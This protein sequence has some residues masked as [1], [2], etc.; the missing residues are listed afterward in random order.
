M[1]RQNARGLTA[2]EMGVRL[3]DV[4]G[5]ELA[6]IIEWMIIRL[7]FTPAQH[8]TEQQICALFEVSRSPVRE[9][10][11]QLES[12]GLVVRQ[13]RKGIRVTPMT[14][15]HVDEI[16]FVRTPLESIAAQCAAK[17]ASKSDI[18]FLE[19]S[20][21]ALDRALKRDDSDAFFDANM[22]YFERVHS[23][24]GNGTLENILRTIEKQA[25]RYRYFAHKFSKEMQENS[26]AHLRLIVES[27]RKGDSDEAYKRTETMMQE[28]HKL[29][30][31]IL[32]QHSQF[33]KM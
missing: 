14:H 16:Y 25:M 21:A 19:K 15:E 9:A 32:R 7:E 29:I 4:L 6:Q 11:R 5:L 17:N 12:I 10:F 23:I 27:I 13:T 2:R 18:A 8:L 3:P 28:A 31:D 1:Q 24:T 26:A 22:A 33:T 20:I 30:V